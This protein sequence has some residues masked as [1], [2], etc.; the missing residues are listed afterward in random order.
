MPA[1]LGADPLCESR[2]A[3]SVLIMQHSALG[4]PLLAWG[5]PVAVAV[6]IWGCVSVHLAFTV[7]REAEAMLKPT[8]VM[9][10]AC[11]IAACAAGSREQHRSLQEQRQ[12]G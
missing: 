1:Q 8:R 11:E 10:W 6:F 12:L 9:L 4:F 2:T 5:T 7:S 3:P